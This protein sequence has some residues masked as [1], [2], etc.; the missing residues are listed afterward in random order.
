LLAK[1]IHA[2]LL[3][4]DAED[5]RLLQ[6][7][8]RGAA[9]GQFELTVVSR[10]A[11][12]I[13]RLERGE[14]EIVLA[15]L[16]VPDSAGLNTFLQLHAH[17]ESLPIVVLSSL[18]DDEV[19]LRAVQEGAQEFLVKGQA[20]GALIAR[21]LRH[22]VERHKHASVQVKGARVPGARVVAFIGARGGVGTTT[23]AA[24]I[25]T[26]LAQRKSRV[27]LVE[28]RPCLGPLSL[29]LKGAPPVADLR[30]VLDIEPEKLNESE[31][32]ARLSPTTFELRILYG[33]QKPDAFGE[34]DAAKAAHL[35]ETLALRADHL[36]IDL[37]SQITEASR[38]VFERAAFTAIVV[39]RDPACV[40]FASHMV[41]LARNWGTGGVHTGAILVNRVTLNS[42]VRLPD[43]RSQLQC[44]V[45]GVIPPAADACTYAQAAGVPLVLADPSQLAAEAFAEIAGRLAVDPVRAARVD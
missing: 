10:V 24:N 2:L 25:A 37:P 34:I 7:Q 26:S 21:T 32:A 41:T 43:V 35:I 40:A 39:E 13:Q 45:M 15:D 33:P 29:Y 4:D 6:T 9:P 17:A 16:H 27:I 14:F 38:A 28:L 11:E 42:P 36:V 20:S 5:A 19:A 23:V 44:E 3:E 22:A 8:L 18:T 30:E 31:L 12:A 1:P